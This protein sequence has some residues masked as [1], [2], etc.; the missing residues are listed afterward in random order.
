MLKLDLLEFQLFVFHAL[1][2]SLQR[3]TIYGF[4][5]QGVSDTSNL[6]LLLTKRSQMPYIRSINLLVAGSISFIFQQTLYL[7]VKGSLIEI[8]QPLCYVRSMAS[9]K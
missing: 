3:D 7:K 5:I 9:E 1:V 2:H 6:L 4:R 8:S